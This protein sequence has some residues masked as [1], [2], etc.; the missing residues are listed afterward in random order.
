[1]NQIDQ[2]SFTRTSNSYGVIIDIEGNKNPTYVKSQ[3]KYNSKNHKSYTYEY[4]QLNNNLN[5]IARVKF[6]L[7]ELYPIGI[8]FLNRNIFF[9]NSD[10]RLYYYSLDDKTIT[11]IYGFDSD[12]L[13]IKLLKDNLLILLND[14][15]FIINE[16][17]EVIK[18]FNFGNIES[19]GEAKSLVSS[20]DSSIVVE[21]YN[22]K[23][24][25]IQRF[26]IYGNPLDDFK[27][28]NNIVGGM[29][30]SNNS[31]SN[32]IIYSNERSV[33]LHEWLP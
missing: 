17:G 24:T 14:S 19:I 31:N 23:F 1:M 5:L 20:T 30:I 3:L 2:N 15:L 25:T 33:F 13:D 18:G 11:S 26:S 6:D 21:F 28:K 7:G 27:I 4:V 10:N 12:I 29:H 9:Y 16:F 22:N 32:I 8:N